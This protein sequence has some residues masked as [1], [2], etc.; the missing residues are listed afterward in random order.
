[1]VFVFESSRIRGVLVK[2]RSC[3]IVLCNKYIKLKIDL[4]LSI[5]FIV[6]NYY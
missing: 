4:I 5:Q 6:L 2:G 3:I 1:M